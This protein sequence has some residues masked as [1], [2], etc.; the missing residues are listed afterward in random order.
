MQGLESDPRRSERTMQFYFKN[1]DSQARVVKLTFTGW[2]WP[3]SKFCIQSMVCSCT[4]L[5][6]Q[7]LQRVNKRPNEL[8]SRNRQTWM[9]N[10]HGNSLY[11]WSCHLL[12]KCPVMYLP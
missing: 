1:T 11:V 7:R 6:P 2:M 8:P 4:R 3:L 9:I 12:S 5:L 10:Y